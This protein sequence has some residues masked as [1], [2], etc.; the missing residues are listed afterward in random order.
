M[1]AVHTLYKKDT[2]DPFILIHQLKI[3]QDGFLLGP[4]CKITS[5]GIQVI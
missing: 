3:G 2:S 4:K 1:S 5:G